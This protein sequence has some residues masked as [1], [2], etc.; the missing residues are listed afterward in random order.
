VD[1]DRDIT[2]IIAKI[3]NPVFEETYM[4]GRVMILSE[5]VA[6]ALGELQ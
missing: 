2:A 3:G 4:M 5:A 6:L 1:L